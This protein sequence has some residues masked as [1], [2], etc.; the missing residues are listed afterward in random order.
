MSSY[1]IDRGKKG[2]RNTA[3]SVANEL[4]LK[5]AIN[6]R[7]RELLNEYHVNEETIDA[8]TAFIMRQNNELASKLGAIKELNKVLG[9]Y[10]KDNEQQKATINITYG[11]E[12]SKKK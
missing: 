3:S 11:W 6:T 2:W 12:E 4:L 7:I 5:P 1:N 8:E 10:S 9:R